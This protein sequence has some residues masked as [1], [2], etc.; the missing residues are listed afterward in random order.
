[1]E[2]L[3][4]TMGD[5]LTIVIFLCGIIGLGIQNWHRGLK[6][7]LR[8]TSLETRIGGHEANCR[9]DWQVMNKRFDRLTKAVYVSIGSKMSDI[10]KAEDPDL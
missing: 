9:E 3:T 4:F 6:S 10:L 7:E 5:V 2:N 1:M 8:I